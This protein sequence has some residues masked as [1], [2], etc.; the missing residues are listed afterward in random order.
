VP[1][2]AFLLEA[3]VVDETA[4]SRGA[5]EQTLLF[6]VGIDAEF[7]TRPFLHA[8]TV[9]GR[10]IPGNAPAQVSEAKSLNFRLS[11]ERRINPAVVEA[12]LPRPE[13]QGLRRKGP[14]SVPSLT[15][16]NGSIERFYN[17]F[18]TQ[19]RCCLRSNQAFCS[20]GLFSKWRHRN[21]HA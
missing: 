10:D 21:L 7:E 18:D 4:A 17:V 15:E 6:P 8:T 2:E 5:A 3:E 12:A 1:F 11:G 9:P 20:F 14:I 19:T 16:S 13:G